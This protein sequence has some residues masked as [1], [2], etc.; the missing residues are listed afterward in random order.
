M[1]KNEQYESIVVIESKVKV[2]FLH[3]ERC[4]DNVDFRSEVLCLHLVFTSLLG[5]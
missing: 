3:I 1:Y 4:K 5:S 2:R